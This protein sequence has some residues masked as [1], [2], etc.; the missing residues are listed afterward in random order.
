MLGH[1]R[2]DAREHLVVR[3]LVRRVAVQSSAENRHTPVHAHELG[4]ELL[5]CREVV[6]AVPVGDDGPRRRQVQL[7][8]AIIPPDA[9]RGGVVAGGGRV[10]AKGGHGLDAQFCHDLGRPRR[11]H[12]VQRPRQVGV[13]ERMRGNGF[14]QQQFHVLSRQKLLDPVERGPSCQGV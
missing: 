3:G 13:V 14:A 6:L 11:E 9:R 4:H 1:D 8:G 5:K 7:A 10:Q 2:T 12:G